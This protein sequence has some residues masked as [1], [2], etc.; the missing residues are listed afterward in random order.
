MKDTKKT[1]WSASLKNLRAILGITQEELAEIVGVSRILIKKAEAKKRPLPVTQK[2]GTMI[3][4]ATGATIGLSKLTAHGFGPY[5]PLKGNAVI[6]AWTRKGVIPFT[7][8]AFKDHRATRRLDRVDDM[9]KTLTILF[10][11][12]SRVETGKLHGLRWSFM[13]WA[14]EAAERFKLPVPSQDTLVGQGS[15]P[16]GPKKSRSGAKPGAQAGP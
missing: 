3:Q 10:K 2:L 8:E 5:E 7:L 15:F 1:N 6:S 16:H 13:E 11:A 4:M 9:V 12:A 14:R